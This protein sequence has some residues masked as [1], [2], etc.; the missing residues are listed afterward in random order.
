M[1]TSKSSSEQLFA[2]DTLFELTAQLELLALNAAVE[3]SACDAIAGGKITGDSYVGDNY[4]G[5]EK[6]CPDSLE[7]LLQEVRET[8]HWVC[9]AEE[10]D[11]GLREGLS[12]LAQ[13]LA[14]TVSDLESPR[15][16]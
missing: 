15:L 9:T 3:T 8:L 14:Q 16:H 11:P 7:A 6:S 13:R 5:N 12:R 1:P 10:E 2:A 4:V